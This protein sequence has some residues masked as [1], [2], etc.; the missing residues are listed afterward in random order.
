MAKYAFIDVQNTDIT[1]KKLL[2]FVIDWPKLY[3]FLR[4]KWLCK[5]VFIYIGV[6]EGDIDTTT[7]L[8]DLG[9]QGCDV[10]AKTI[11]AYK[12]KDKD[13]SVQC[14]NCQH[15]YIEHLDMGYNRKSNCDVDLTVDAMDM[16]TRDDEYYLFTGDGDFEYMVRRLLSKGLKIHI[17]SNAKKVKTGP[18]YFTSRFST[19]LRRLV[20]ENPGR[21]DFINIDNIKRKIQKD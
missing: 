1:A 3:F 9:K 2:G 18:Q 13:F 6:D 7:M 14:P 17:V 16:A 4:D 11:F 19:K 12:N 21:V 5:R 10:R 20:S 8:E 15:T